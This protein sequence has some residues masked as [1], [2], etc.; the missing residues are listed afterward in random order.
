MLVLS[1][2]AGERIVINPGK[3]E[4]VVELLEISTSKRVR[5]GI[6]APDHIRVYRDELLP[7]RKPEER[8]EQ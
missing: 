6:H 1:R 5:I 3:D 8:H 4:I 2:K 7:L